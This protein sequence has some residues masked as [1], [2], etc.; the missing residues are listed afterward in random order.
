M[1]IA[2]STKHS[3]LFASALALVQLYPASTALRGLSSCACYRLSAP[4][5]SGQLRP[6]ENEEKTMTITDFTLLIDALTRLVAALAT[7]VI[8]FRRHRL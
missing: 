1:V 8:A 4:S 3:R 7:V 2:G 6:T 5:M